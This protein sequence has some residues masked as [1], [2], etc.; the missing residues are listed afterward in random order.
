MPERSLSRTEELILDLLSEGA[1]MYGL[2][3]VEA[4]EG[5]L[6]RGTVYV[7]L[8]RMAEKGYVRSRQAPRAPGESGLPRRLYQA[9]PL[10]LRVARAWSRLRR[11]LAWGGAQ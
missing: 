1:E 11:E 4:A 3:M 9:T 10:G 7:T 6:K 5:Q 2:E 8:G